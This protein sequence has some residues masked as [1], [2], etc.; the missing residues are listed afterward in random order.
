LARVKLVAESTQGPEMESD[1][2]RIASRWAS[3]PF[4]R[5]LGIEVES[6]EPGRATLKM[7][8]TEKVLNGGHGVLHGGVVST[9]IDCAIAVALH[10]ANLAAA[11]GSVGQTTTDL[12]VSF[13]AGAREGPITAEGRLV[14][15]G[16]TLA[17]GEATVRDGNGATVA[18]GRGTF[19][20]LRSRGSQRMGPSEGA[21]PAPGSELG[22][23]GA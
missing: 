10:S 19:M 4:L 21:A 13:L 8:V 20:I 16:G 12:N 23:Q 2:E 17:V 11:E 5:L 6:F 14:R 18:V 7:P 9:L 1:R 22:R 3:D 15:R